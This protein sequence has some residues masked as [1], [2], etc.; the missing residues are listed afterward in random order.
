MTKTTLYIVAGAMIVAGVATGI[1]A[2]SHHPSPQTSAIITSPS[3]TPVPLP[4]SQSSSAPG[5]ATSNLVAGILEGSLTYPA[6]GIPN[7]L[8]VC[9]VNLG[10]GQATCTAERLREGRFKGGVGYQ[11]TVPPG[12]YQVYAMA[13]SFDPNYKAY[14]SRFVT[15]GYSANCMDH[16]PITVT[17]GAGQ[18]VRGVEPGDFY[19]N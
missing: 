10:S 11:L 1:V 6:Q 13:P 5:S 15:C 18:T 12:N 9:A 3:A 7:D 8:S 4:S 16:S 17:I 2:G 19:R 14:Y